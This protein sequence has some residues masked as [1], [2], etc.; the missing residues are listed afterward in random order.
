MYSVVFVRLK[1]LQM[2]VLALSTVFVNGL[3]TVC[4]KISIFGF[5][6]RLKVKL[7]WSSYQLFLKKEFIKNEVVH[8]GQKTIFRRLH[9][10]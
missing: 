6:N 2:F 10:G 3:S 7:I 9:Y 4:S 1:Q 8:H 5:A